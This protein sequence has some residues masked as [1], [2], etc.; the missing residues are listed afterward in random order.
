MR[1]GMKNHRSRTTKKKER[2][3]E[4]WSE[5]GRWVHIADTWTQKEIDQMRKYLIKLERQRYRIYEK[6]EREMCQQ[7]KADENASKES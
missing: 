4:T 5:K 6:K 7:Q 2:E 1:N 3:R